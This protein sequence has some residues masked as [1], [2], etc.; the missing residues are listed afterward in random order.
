MLIDFVDFPQYM[1][2]LFFLFAVLG[3]VFVFRG[4]SLTIF[5]PIVFGIN[6]A[7]S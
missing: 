2:V 7:L 3:W 4:I 6:L 1:P 5:D